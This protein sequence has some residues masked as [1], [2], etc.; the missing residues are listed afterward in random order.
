MVEEI[1]VPLGQKVH[2]AEGEFGV[3]TN[4]VANPKTITVEFVVVQQKE[5][6]QTEYLVPFSKIKTSDE[7]GI[8]LDAT[9]GEV[10]GMRVFKE[11]QFIFTSTDK[12]GPVNLLGDA[13][14]FL[15]LPFTEATTKNL[16]IL[17]EENIPVGS[18]TIR[19]GDHVHATDGHAGTVDEFIVTPK[20]DICHIVM[21]EDHFL[22]PE[23]EYAIPVK[24]VERAQEGIV[25]LNITKNAI[26]E[27]PVVQVHRWWE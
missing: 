1:R 3:S 15:V 20:G 10:M 9:K 5:A 23:K 16:S 26:E 22:A 4:L 27:L 19:R 12:T 21:R 25:T 7:H 17:E 8:T 11:A 14:Q 2:V 6:P 24:H 13:G 18:L